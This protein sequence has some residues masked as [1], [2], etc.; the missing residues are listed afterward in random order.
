MRGITRIEIVAETFPAYCIVPEKSDPNVPVKFCQ[1]HAWIIKRPE[2]DQISNNLP[3][4]SYHER[5][6]HFVMDQVVVVVY[7]AAIECKN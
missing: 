6:A 4:T 5:L 3:L 2:T 7:Y 1:R